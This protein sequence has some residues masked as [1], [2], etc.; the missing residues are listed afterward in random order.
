MH[1]SRRHTTPLSVVVIEPESVSLQNLI[2]YA[3]HKAHRTLQTH[4]TLTKLADAFKPALRRTDLM[5]EHR[6]QGRLLIVCP[7]T[8]PEELSTLTQRLQATADENDLIVRF[9]YASFPNEAFTFDEL[10]LQAELHLRA[11]DSTTQEAPEPV[12]VESVVLAE[13]K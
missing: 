4:C 1:F 6:Q 8:A 9:G 5:I 7:G 10:I 12:H 2:R 13:V 3:L 11:P